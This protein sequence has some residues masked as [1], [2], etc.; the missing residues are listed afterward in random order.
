MKAGVRIHQYQPTFTHAKLL[1]VDGVFSVIGSA[2]LD[3]RSRQINDEV[4][5]GLQDAAFTQ[6]LHRAWERDLG[7][8]QRIDPAAWARRGLLQRFLEIAS[9]VFVQQY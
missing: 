2:N 7:R 5:I 4:A 1:M 8:A 6:A 3:I 9:Q